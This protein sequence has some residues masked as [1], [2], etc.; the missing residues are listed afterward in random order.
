MWQYAPRFVDADK[1]DSSVTMVRTPSGEDLDVVSTALATELGHGARVLKQGR[2]IF[3]AFPLSLITT[4]TVSAL[5]NMVGADLD[6]RRFRPNL[7]VAGAGG[8]P[9]TEDQWVGRVRH[10][11][12]LTMRVDKRDKRCVTINID[13][14]TSLKN[15]AVLRAVAQQRDAHLGVYGSVVKP[16]RVTVGD[17]VVIE[18]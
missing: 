15:P 14:A 3:D 7:V 12:A 1:P 10:I 17:A 9:F 8:V 6:T 16:G 4:Q 13:P 5:G 11:G 2:G 18:G